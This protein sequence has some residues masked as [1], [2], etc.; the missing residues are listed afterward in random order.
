MEALK[1]F[2]AFVGI[3]ME[4]I[5]AKP[6]FCSELSG[7]SLSVFGPV[8]GIITRPEI[9]PGLGRRRGLGLGVESGLEPPLEPNSSLSLL[10][11]E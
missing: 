2:G 1:T 3:E 6:T 4:V 10:A 8:S 11:G 5:L 7:L 9:E